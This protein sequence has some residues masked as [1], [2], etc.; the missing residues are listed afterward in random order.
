MSTPHDLDRV[1]EA[2]FEDGPTVMTDRVLEAIRDDVDRIDV[3]A[4][5]GSWR[6]PLMLRSMFAAVV[7]VAV[8]LGGLAIY[9]AINQS[10]DVGPPTDS[11]APVPSDDGLS[12]L[13]DEL[14]YPFL[15]PAKEI[16]G[17]DR[18]D[19]GDLYF[20]DGRVAYE[21]G[22]R[23][24]FAS[25]PALTP[26]GDLRLTT[27]LPGICV[28]GDR[29]TYAWSLSPGGT[30]LTI[31]PGTDDCDVRAQVIP[32][33]YQRAACRS[34]N[35]DCLGELESGQYVSHY[36]EPRPDGEWAARHGALAF[37]V[38]GGW[39]AYADFP[40]VFGLT[41]ASAYA[42]FDGQ[43]CYDCPGGDL[44]TV[45]GQPGAATED[46]LETNVLGIGSGAQDLVDWLTAH[47]GLVT[48][49]PEDVTVG[50]LAAT[51]LIIEGSEDW[52]GTCEPE[53]PFV[54]VPIF[55]RQDSYHW[56]LDVGVRYHI[57][58]VD[59]GDGDT[60]AIVVDTAD[61]GDLDTFV[62]T[63]RPIIESFRFPSR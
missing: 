46:C 44:I 3:R 45:L 6:N 11:S 37:T 14:L 32:G 29:G 50:G 1:M 56:A 24:A 9:S 41:P 4:D 10:P 12:A 55:Y 59:L 48:S 26:D 20:E 22:G 28:A 54:A 5:V 18:V 49:E 17:M 31:E 35:N 27:E 51:S 23:A 2:F 33:T 19:R 53:N 39:A 43:D 62:E 40:D 38:P 25:V 7:V 30:I 58:L 15:G 42:A 34:E 60:V 13:P 16:A 52:T 47:P 8:L 21:V 57:T 36:F 61:D 63:A